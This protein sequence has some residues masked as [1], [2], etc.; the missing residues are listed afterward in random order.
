[1]NNQKPKGFKNIASLFLALSLVFLL[2]N[3]IYAQI[4]VT[5]PAEKSIFQ[6]SNSN[7]STIYVGGYFT[8]PINKVEARLV[9]VITGQG[10]ATGWTTIQTNPT[11][12]VYFGNITGQGGWYSL[13]VRGSLNGTIIGRDVVSRVGVGEVF[14][15]AGQSNAEGIHNYG[16]VG[17]SDE[18]VNTVLF[19]NRTQASVSDPSNISI[20]PITAEGIIGPRGR[21]AWCWGALG[22]LLVKRLN[23]PVLFMN[24]GWE[25]TPIKQW[26][27]SSKGI[28]TQNIFTGEPLPPGQPYANLRMAL[29]YYGSVLGVRAVLWVQGET[30]NY[31]K[32]S[33]NDY[34][35]ALQSLIN[36]ARA[37]QGAA[38]YVPWVL[39]RTSRIDIGISQD[40]I[41]GQNAVIASSFNKA[42]EGPYTDNIQ[43]PRVD[44]VHFKNE[45]LI[46]VARA[47]DES[48]PSRFFANTVP[49]TPKQAYGISV[50]CNSNNSSINLKA[51]DGFRVYTWSNGQ[52]TQTITVSAPGS[53]QVVMKDSEG[54]TIYTPTLTLTEPVQPPAPVITPS[55]EQYICAD[56]AITLR[57]NV[58]AQ[59]TVTWSNGQVGNSIV[60]KNPGTFTAKISNVFG[61]ASDVSSPVTVKTLTVQPPTISTLGIYNL[62]AQS[63]SAIFKLADTKVSN[64]VWEWKLNGKDYPANSAIIKATQDGDYSARSKITFDAVTGGSTRVCYSPY[65]KV[66]TGYKTASDEG[67]VL[68]PNPN[69]TGQLA[70]ETL[71][72][73]TNV[74]ISVTS[75]NGQMVYLQ[76]FDTLNERKILN[77]VSLSEGQYIVRL[78]STG[79]NQTKKIIIER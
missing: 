38:V 39:S 27:D 9:P 58:S 8:Q 44:G 2:K 69:K 16:A 46:A 6:R 36:S 34:Q 51:P 20:G 42:Y 7:E 32:I 55:G 30:D 60:V 14:I 63:D 12:G 49:V 26:F 23:V 13:E 57:V 54:N 52:S 5:Y 53:Y 48:M 76:K 35:G 31:L 37:D 67:L 71:R 72:D 47:W 77:L 4:K 40:I 19:N 70:I 66:L 56:S 64:I 33:K 78:T 18:R 73:L 17:A 43:V 29:K 24:V 45:G 10:L 1:M 15:V 3:H 59:N 25:S 75:L 61:C 68:Y 22:D 65:S 79:F 50:A 62:Q 74:E 11:N 21:S 41:D 28:A